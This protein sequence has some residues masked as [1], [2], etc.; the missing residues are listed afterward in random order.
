MLRIFANKKS[1]P[2]TELLF[3]TNLVGRAGFEPATRGL[4]TTPTFA[5]R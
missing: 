3:F 4:L 2:K 5:S 1:N